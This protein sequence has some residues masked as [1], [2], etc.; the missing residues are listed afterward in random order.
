MDRSHYKLFSKGSIAGM[1]LSNRLVRS[2]TWDP[3]ILAALRMTEE[4]LDLYRN[5]ALGGIGMII[6]GGLAVY[7]DRSPDEDSQRPVR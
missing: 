1:T 3:S 4:V 6:S 7:R 5:L 2:A